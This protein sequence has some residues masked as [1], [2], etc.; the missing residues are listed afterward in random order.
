MR[1]E[2]YA[3]WHRFLDS[4]AKLNYT[5]RMSQA[6]IRRKRRAAD[7][8]APRRTAHYDSPGASLGLSRARTDDL[9]L[10]VRRGL[11][12]E[13]L[14]KFSFE[15]G[16]P[17]AAVALM[18]E[19]P[20]RTLAR[21][22]A[23]G[24]LAPDESERLLRISGVFEKAVGLFEGGVAEAIAWLANPKK[25]LANHSPLE[26]ARFEVGAREVENLIGRLEHGVFT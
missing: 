5:F 18:I 3:R 13:A 16:F 8:L 2:A 7:R 10:A 14:R 1:F 24:R 25:A 6:V 22:K 4:M 9:I 19:I 26:Y 11:P 17:P 21:R 23:D 12:Y 15:T 20:E